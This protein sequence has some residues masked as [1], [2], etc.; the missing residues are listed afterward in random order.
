[1]DLKILSVIEEQIAVE[2]TGKVNV[3]AS[4]NRQYL[5]HILFR[6]GDILQVV[7]QSSKGLKA[8]YQI[9]I[10]EISLKNFD[11][12]VEPEIVDEKERQIHY[13]YG[14]I[15][16]KLA[17]V[18]KLHRE[19]LKLRPPE[20]VKM[21]IDP[22]FLHGSQAVT[23]Q[24]FAVLDTLTEWNSPYDV[25]QHCNLLDHE[26]T[27]ALVSLRKKGALK[28]LAQKNIS[29]DQMVKKQ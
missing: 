10:Q 19:S 20:H 13:P 27:H 11:Y 3:L 17:E 21:I 24:E 25:Y 22:S 2:F 23:P 15:K 1:M 4:F 29:D 14:V 9:I 16:A 26:I 6:S 7:F 8:F 5:G 28:I 18:I 12:V